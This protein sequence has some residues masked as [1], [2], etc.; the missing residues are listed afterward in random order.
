M[1]RKEE[2]CPPASSASSEG[3]SSLTATTT[4]KADDSPGSVARRRRPKVSS[5]ST[6]PTASRSPSQSGARGRRRRWPAAPPPSPPGCAPRSPTRLGRRPAAT[7]PSGPPARPRRRRTFAA[8]VPVVEEGA[9]PHEPELRRSRAD[10]LAQ[11]I[12]ADLAWSSGLRPEGL[13]IDR[14]R[15]SNFMRV[16][17]QLEKLQIFG[18]FVCLDTM[19]FVFTLLPLRFF[20]ALATILG[21]CATRI[22]PGRLLCGYGRARRVRA[23]RVHLYDVLRATLIVTTCIAL[24]RVHMSRIYHYIRTQSVIKLYLLFGMLDIFDRLFTAL[25]QD[26]L[27]TLY[28]STRYEPRH[29]LQGLMH[30]LYA[31]V[32]VL[33]HSTLKFV[34]LVTL[35]VAINSTSNAVLT[36]L[37]SSNFTEMK[38]LVFKRFDESNVFQ[39]SCADIVERFV[40]Y[41]F[42]A[43]VFVQNFR[44]LSLGSDTRALTNYLRVAAMISAS[45]CLVDG[46]KHAFITKFNGLSA[47]SY[48][49]YATIIGD[50]L[51]FAVATR[52][53]STRRWTRRTA[54][55]RGWGLRPSRWRVIVRVFLGQMHHIDLPTPW[56]WPCAAPSLLASLFSVAVH[57]P[58]VLLEAQWAVGFGQG[59]RHQE[60]GGLSLRGRRPRRSLPR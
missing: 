14:R 18:C 12:G 38:S 43:L 15:V 54:S 60:G 32:Y 48:A 29:T 4:P 16:P 25:G 52:S 21:A 51:A 26:V 22:V 31:Q 5:R 10:D 39:I 23:H 42:L 11:F 17:L 53:R 45:E 6:S 46:I 33:L 24:Q 28:Y 19:L 41:V 36:L 57:A 44:E 56:A 59:R 20:M 40:L 1:P 35:T 47:G 3:E 8:A 9:P 50:D 2:H 34:Q 27:Q 13:D 37:I 7:R 55:R 30:F 49:K 58:G